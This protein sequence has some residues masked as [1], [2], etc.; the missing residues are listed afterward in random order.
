MMIY[1]QKGC[2][3]IECDT[4]YTH[5]HSCF[6]TIILKHMQLSVYGV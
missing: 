1:N 6:A 4:V 5:Y 2:Q 3:L